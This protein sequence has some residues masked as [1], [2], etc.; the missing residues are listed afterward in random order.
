MR[1]LA[2]YTFLL[3]AL[4]PA[5]GWTAVEA[6]DSEGRLVSLAEPAQRIVA[7]AP[8][9][10]E[11]LYSIGAGDQIVGAV[12]YSDYPGAARDIPRVGGV[13]SISLERI[14]A[15][16]PDLVI[17]WGSGT[18]PQLR[19]ALERLGKP[20][21]VDEI[22]S[23]EELARQFRALGTLTGHA[24]AALVAAESVHA[25]LSATETIA[26]E[27]REEASRAVFLQIWDEPLQSVGGDHLLS[28]VIHRCGGHSISRDLPGLAP[29]VS[30]ERVLA[31]DPAL[32]IVENETQAE[33]WQRWPQLQAVRGDGILVIHADFLHRPTLRLLEGMATICARLRQH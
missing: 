20:V 9:V 7:L 3:L 21:F 24:D 33:H 1:S 31:A 18:S 22:R 10:V 30:L 13:G 32:I 14:I 11:N 17:A 12:Q 29:L 8:H 28:E 5:A 4:L 26:A 15:A 6:R 23:L 2:S 27:T 19:A 25:A 16:D